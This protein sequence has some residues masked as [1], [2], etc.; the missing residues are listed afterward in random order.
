MKDLTKLENELKTN[1]INKKIYLELTGDIAYRIKIEDT[2]FLINK[3]GLIL[4]DAEENQIAISFDEVET[5]E[6]QENLINIYFN[7]NERIRIFT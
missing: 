4:S 6:T 7:Y 5:I 1:F 3:L 2:K